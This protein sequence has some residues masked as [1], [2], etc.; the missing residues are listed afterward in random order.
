MTPL[1]EI[2]KAVKII[3][4]GSRIKVCMRLGGENGEMLFNRYRFS[5]SLHG[6]KFGDG[7]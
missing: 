3:E 1:Y 2:L 5:I 4:T 6:N 7:Y